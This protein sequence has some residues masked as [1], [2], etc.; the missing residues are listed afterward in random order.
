MSGPA[1][2][3]AGP[4]ASRAAGTTASGGEDIAGSH[5]NSAARAIAIVEFLA[6][7][8][9]QTFTLSDIAR[10]CGL[11]KSTAYTILGTLHEAGWL[12]RSPADLR[13]GLGPTLITIGKM[14][15]EGRPEVSLARP[16]MQ[17]LAVE[18]QRECVLSTA[19]GDEILVLE[20][21]GAAGVRGRALQSGQRVP[22]VA[23]FGTVFV[24][25]QDSPGRKEWYQR[26]ALA[27]P[28][29]IQE[30]EDILDATVRRGYVV[31]L[32][33]DPHDRM[34]QIMDA[35]SDELTI[36]DVRRMLREQLSHL[37]PVEYLVGD[38][39]A[40]DRQVVET[41]QA[42]IFDAEQ[43]PRYALTVN[44]IDRKL[45]RDTVT[46]LGARV[47]AA[48]DQVSAAIAAHA[49]Q[50]WNADSPR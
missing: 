39:A 40:D 42:P 15:E 6:S 12:T 35:V 43:S 38:Q 49:R 16:V 27:E 24:A 28:E 46:R 23:P 50:L 13:Y 29:R 45:D 34:N 31:T 37:P 21:T 48:A 1:A 36:P 4:A 47:R 8:P 22:M 9:G 32:K 2:G 26:S 30:L 44:D 25:W 5:S 18:L 14:A 19:M 3:A 33:S 41:L 17:A 20:S 7:R 10:R 11:R